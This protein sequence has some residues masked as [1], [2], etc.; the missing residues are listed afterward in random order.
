MAINSRNKGA[1]GEREVAK[2]IED[3]LGVTC[4]RNLDQWRSGGFDLEGLDGWAIEVKRAKKPLLESWW[5]QTVDQA[6]L[7]DLKPVLWWRLD[8]QKWNV[9]VPL[10]LISQGLEYSQG[11]DYT[12]RLSP[13]GFACLIR[14]KYSKSLDKP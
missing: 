10:N 1:A 9:V 8:N 6:R 13:E 14:E 5:Q 3:L 11:L 2:I 4:Q 12:A 7:A